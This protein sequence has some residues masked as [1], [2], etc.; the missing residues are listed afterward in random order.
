MWHSIS[1][2]VKAARVVTDIETKPQ[3]QWVLEDD[4][5]VETERI[6]VD[7]QV[8]PEELDEAALRA[9][10]GGYQDPEGTPGGWLGPRH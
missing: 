2:G 1:A 8:V 9:P 10:L 7:H 6:A 4:D 5:S 3:P